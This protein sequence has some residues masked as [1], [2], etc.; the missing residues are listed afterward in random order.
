[1]AFRSLAMHW[2]NRSGTR[3]QTAFGVTLPDDLSAAAA[4]APLVV[5]V[6]GFNSAPERNDTLLTPIRAAGFPCGMFR[7]PNDQPIARSAALLSRE[8]AAL[9][10]QHPDRHVAL[11]SYSMGALVAR[12]AVENPDL[13]PGNVA[14]LLMVAPPSQGTSCAHVG[15]SADL[16]E[17]G[18]RREG[19]GL[20]DRV[21]ASFEDG[22]GEARYD[23]VPDSPFL[24][25]LNGRPRNPRV[26]YSIFLGSGGTLTPQ[27]LDQAQRLLAKLASDNAA[28]AFFQPA[29]DSLLADLH[30]VCE[31]GDGVVSLARGALDGVA[32]T[33]VLDFGHSS[34]ID[35]PDQPAVETL[36]REILKRLENQRAVASR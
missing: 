36:H 24:K 12:E 29:L 18:V 2:L 1:M 10:R 16:W 22:L 33:V 35:A 3:A 19:R 30:D 17:Y 7:Y 14:S 20:L 5:L 26:T 4:D 25:C 34:V 32:D 11:L 9:A 6:H 31:P 28:V 15:L 13:D 27:Q 23:L 21:Y 8:L